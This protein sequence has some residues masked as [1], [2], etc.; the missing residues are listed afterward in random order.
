MA[1]AVARSSPVALLEKPD[2]RLAHGVDLE[3][4]HVTEADKDSG[5]QG[6]KQK[7]A[8]EPAAA[9]PDGWRLQKP[10]HAGDEIVAAAERREQTRRSRRRLRARHLDE[11]RREIEARSLAHGIVVGGAI[12]AL[13]PGALQRFRRG[14]EG[15][16]V[17]ARAEEQPRQVVPAAV[18]RRLLARPRAVVTAPRC[19]RTP[20]PGARDAL[21]KKIVF[22]SVPG[23]S[24]A[25]PR[26]HKTATRSDCFPASRSIYL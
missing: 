23:R 15:Q 13:A 17:G 8:V 5:D 1:T 11:R 12:A 10:S 6:A 2:D 24:A 16:Q 9:P 18:M 26:R 7:D 25:P 21:L 19:G 20:V 4:R 14:A 22:K 3:A